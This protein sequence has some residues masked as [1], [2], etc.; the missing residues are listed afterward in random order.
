MTEIKI[1]EELLR[2][3]VHKAILEGVGPA[4]RDL[5]MVS[6]LEHLTAVPPSQ[7][8]GHKP[9]SPLQEAFNSAVG[10]VCFEV[11]RELVTEDPAFKAK[12]ADLMRGAMATAL[13][14]PGTGNVAG[15]RF[16][17]QMASAMSEVLAD[18]WRSRE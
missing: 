17:E 13:A 12:V 11:A 18:A 14:K 3:I 1:D 6:A 2:G 10:R 8:Y 15:E 4:Q 7:G 16:Q 9:I 5:L